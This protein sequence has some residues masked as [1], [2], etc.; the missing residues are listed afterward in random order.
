MIYTQLMT[1]NSKLPFKVLK[2][3]K[4]FV[5]PTAGYCSKIVS[6]R[7]VKDFVAFTQSDHREIVEITLSRSPNTLT[8]PPLFLNKQIAI[9]DVLLSLCC[10]LSL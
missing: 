6:R 10:D 1:S 7:S 9:A 3:S 5:S 2:S 8:S 4:H